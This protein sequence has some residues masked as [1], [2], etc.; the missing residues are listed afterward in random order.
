MKFMQKILKKFMPALI[1]AYLIIQSFFSA[2]ST[3]PAYAAMK[4][5]TTGPKPELARIIR[6]NYGVPH[7]FAKNIFDL[8][9]AYGYVT[10]EDRLFQI[11]MLRRSVQGRV[12]EILGKDFIELD[13]VALREGYSNTEIKMRIGLLKP[14]YQKILQ[15]FADGINKKINEIKDGSAGLPVEFQEYGFMS[16]SWSDVDV[17]SIFIGTMAVRY[18]DITYEMD[19]LNLIKFLMQTKSREDAYKILN[20]IAPFNELNT[21]TTFTKNKNAQLNLIKQDN[22]ELQ[23]AKIESGNSNYSSYFDKRKKWREQLAIIGFPVKLGSYAYCVS[24]KKSKS[25]N[26]ILA[27]GPQMGFF[28]PAYLFEVGLHSP[29]YNVTGTTNPCYMNI[30]FGMNNELSFTSTAGAANTTD[31]YAETLNPQNNDE[32]LFKGKYLKFAKKVYEIKVKGEKS[33]VTFEVL[34]SIHG[35]VF[36][37]DAKN[38]TA[39]SKRRA[40]EN[41]ELDSMFA[42]MEAVNSKNLAEFKTHACHN[43]LA[44]NFI[45][46]DSKG[47]I[48]HYLCGRYPIR[49]AGFDD[50]IP[51]PGDGSAEW[52]GFEDQ[53]NNPQCFNPDCGFIANWNCKPYA[54]Y[55]NGDIATDWGI[56]QRTYLI[57]NLI[58]S[59]DKIDF[60]DMKEINKKLGH[61][62]LRGPAYVPV[63]IKNLEQIKPRS[64]TVEV[65][66]NVLKNWDYSRTDENRDGFYDNPG[67]AL[68]EAIWPELISSVFSKHLGEFTRLVDSFNFWTQSGALYYTLIGNYENG[69]ENDKFLPGELIK[70]E[71]H[72]DYLAGRKS[73]DVVKE[74][75]ENAVAKLASEYKTLNYKKW[76]KKT[77]CL[78]FDSINFTGV[79]QTSKDNKFSILQT[80]RGTENHFVELGPNVRT[81]ENINPP[82]QSAYRGADGQNSPHIKDQLE[83]FDGYRGYKKMLWNIDEIIK[84]KAEEKFIIKK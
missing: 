60:N 48:L 45:A 3:I 7:I 81:A 6:D 23:S 13:K 71:G 53:A 30:L 17:A 5:D 25:G 76:L 38:N 43:A 15:N 77:E 8:Y 2:G 47:N 52:L 82:G 74:A 31:I 55:R 69:F 24:S 75:V 34:H 10:A 65:A 72:Y 61:I 41:C 32:Y 63:I 62:D 14:E 22:S 16:Q 58:A 79:P 18:S 1:T 78:T 20:D 57:K 33:P 35:P 64:M 54:G 19:N 27:G 44:I 36:E 50:R 21:T 37:F 84:N 83:L 73:S 46:A 59:Y 4:T 29:E 26:A 49:N 80:N 12:S 70:S 40:W 67:T 9:Y 68:F 66:L 51:L 11:E 28:N 42:W 56:D 39:Y